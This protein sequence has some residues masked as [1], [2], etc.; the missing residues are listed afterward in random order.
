M[1]GD[2]VSATMLAIYSR[3]TAI[4]MIAGPIAEVL[5]LFLSRS[6]IPDSIGLIK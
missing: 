6:A 2:H 4:E 5:A 1:D 3:W